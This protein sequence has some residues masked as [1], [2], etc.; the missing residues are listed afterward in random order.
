VNLLLIRKIGQM[1]KELKG[2]S[3]VPSPPKTPKAAHQSPLA[4]LLA[5]DEP[6]Y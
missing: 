3:P 6:Q 4:A 2:K 1:M 5:H